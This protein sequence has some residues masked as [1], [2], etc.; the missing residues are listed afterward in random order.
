MLKFDLPELLGCLDSKSL[1][2]LQFTREPDNKIVLTILHCWLLFIS[3]LKVIIH[4]LCTTYTVTQ[5]RMNDVHTSIFFLFAEMPGQG[6]SEK[7]ELRPVAVPPILQ[8]LHFQVPWA[9]TQRVWS[10]S[11]GKQLA[12]CF[13]CNTELLG[14]SH[15]PIIYKT[16][17]KGLSACSGSP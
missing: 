9:R 8:K 5:V 12:L 3:I 1:K 14:D 17:R 6:P 2:S 4:I 7:M 16:Y 15:S 11:Q 10:T 13:L